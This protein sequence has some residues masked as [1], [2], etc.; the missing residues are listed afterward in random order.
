MSRADIERAAEEKYPASLPYNAAFERAMRDREAYIRGRLDQAEADAQVAETL[1]FGPDG[2]P[3]HQA[4]LH[5][6]GAK[7]AAA[8]IRKGVE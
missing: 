8:A 5:R 1:D 7:Q 2:P 4:S 6:W 3:L